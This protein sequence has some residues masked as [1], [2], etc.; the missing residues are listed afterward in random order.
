[1]VKG[2]ARDGSDGKQIT[3]REGAPA[4]AGSSTNICEPL[5]WTFPAAETVKGS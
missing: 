1:M 3:G 2:T 5:G 4:S